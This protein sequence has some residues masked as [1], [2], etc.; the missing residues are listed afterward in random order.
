MRELVHRGV[1]VDFCSA[2]GATWYDGGELRRITGHG[3]LWGAPA[4]LSLDDAEGPQCP[5]CRTGLEERRSGRAGGPTVDVC[6]R[7]SG[8]LL[9][10]AELPRLQQGAAEAQLE[11]RRE[12]KARAT[13]VAPQ[14]AY[15]SAVAAMAKEQ[16]QRMASRL[17]AAPPETMLGWLF[18]ALGLP[19][20]E[21]GRQGGFPWALTGLVALIVGAGFLE[22]SRGVEY[23][24]TWLAMVPRDVLAGE[25][26]VTVVT[27]MFGHG[28]L[29]HLLGNLYFLWLVGD[30]LEHRYGPLRFL[31]LYLVCGLGG[32]AA[33]LATDAA[34]QVPYLGASGAIAGLMGAYMVLF[35][36]A[37]IVQYLRFYW[38]IVPLALPAWAYFLLWFGSQL[39]GAAVGGSGVGWWAH[40]GGFVVG[41]AIAA[42]TRGM[43]PLPGR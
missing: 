15:A 23:T 9:D 10:R 24:T 6:P 39:V 14:A 5:R 11:R 31:A 21:H 43:E 13:D 29:L 38:R 16:G 28:D 2:C 33:V 19:V 3:F 40:I 4:A 27:S 20:E 41:V 26:V 7:C 42:V 17:P 12:Q 37:R 34:G 18:A 22:V 30:D 35:P 32:Q 36:G 25:R 1:A 8:V